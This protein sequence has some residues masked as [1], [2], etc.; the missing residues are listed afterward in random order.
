MAVDNMK[1]VEFSKEELDKID[2]LL[3]QLEEVLKGK[4]VSLT[5][6]ERR[7]Y[8]RVGNN[9]WS[10]IARAKAYMEQY[11]ETVMVH[12]DKEEH[13]KDYVAYESLRPRLTR[14]E[15]IVSQLSDTLLL[16]GSDLY[17]NTRTYYTGV[18]AGAQTNAPNTKH[19][20]ADLKTQ[21]QGGRNTNK[22]QEE[23][24]K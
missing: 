16:I 20:Y 10:W 11:P 5:P 22:N 18:R 8:S 21:F 24:N 12:L 23:S 15:M 17:K 6:T 2:Q 9:N 13:Q 4:M 19:I 14:L 3:L 7:N 1:S